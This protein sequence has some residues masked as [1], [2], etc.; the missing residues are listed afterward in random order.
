MKRSFSRLFIYV[1][2]AGIMAGFSLD[3]N[4]QALPAD[5]APVNRPLWANKAKQ[6][7]LHAWNGYKKYAWGHDQLKPLSHS[8]YDWYSRS[9]LMTPVDAFDTMKLMHL[10]KQAAE[11]KKLIFS[12][13]SFDVDSYVSTFE[14]T[15]RMLGGLLSSYELDHDKRFLDLAR[16]LG[17]RMLPAFDTPTGMPYEYVNLKTGQTKGDVNSSAEI[18]TLILEFGTLSKLTHDPVYYNKAKKALVALY[19]HRSSIGLVGTTINVKTGKWVNTDSHVSGGID[20]YYEYLVKAWKLFGDRQFKTMY[21]N[22]IQ[23][24]NKYVADSVSTGLWYGHVDMNTGKRTA[25][26]FGALDAYF[27]AVL[28]LGGD[29][30]RAELLEASCYKMWMVAGVEPEQLDYSDMKIINPSYA[31]RPENLESAYYLYH[32]TKNPIY[33]KRG[34]DMFASILK[35]C[36]TDDG[37]AGLKDVRT[38]TQEDYMESFLFAETFKYAYLL[39][40]PPSTLDF[41]KIIFNT[42][43][44]PYL[45]NLK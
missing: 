3:C 29:L 43:A 33:L 44:H 15:I 6:A 38:K 35:Y 2:I 21:D 37:Y 42:E 4:A 20:S 31:L 18:G 23:A 39:F 40:S 30:H 14:I 26:H 7:F 1:F 13:L 16:D 27:P 28:A 17:N 25:T 45:R 10:N 9:L 12:K 22:T 19:N 36:R 8:Y 41:N 32:Y 24:V 34:R 11:A 5:N